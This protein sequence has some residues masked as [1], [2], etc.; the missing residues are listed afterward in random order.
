MVMSSHFRNM[1]SV[2]EQCNLYRAGITGKVKVL[3]RDIQRA[4]VKFTDKET[5]RPEKISGV[6]KMLSFATS[7]DG[8]SPY[9]YRGIFLVNFVILVKSD[10]VI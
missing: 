1:E 2:Y 6:K 10:T 8:Y 3:L 4:K 7:A 9:I 5:A